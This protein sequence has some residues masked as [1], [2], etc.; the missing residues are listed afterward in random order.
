V[1]DKAGSLPIEGFSKASHVLAAVTGGGGHLG[2]FDGPLF[3]SAAKRK[4]RWVLKPV[5]QFFTAAVRDRPS[6]RGSG[7]DVHVTKEADGFSYVEGELGTG[8]GGK[9]VGWK[10]LDEGE[11]VQG[12]NGS[13]VLQGL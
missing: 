4:R 8:R 12:T 10:E 6:S 1:T 2:W 9:R 11:V 13:G 7:V 5:Q 3:G